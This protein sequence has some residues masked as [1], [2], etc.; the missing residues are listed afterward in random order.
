MKSAQIS[1][2]SN[3]QIPVLIAILIVAIMVRFWDIGGVGFNND[4]AV[5]AGQAANLAGYAEF[6]K[7]FFSN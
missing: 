6:E 5:Y 7:Y 3:Y 1:K 4:E 2:F